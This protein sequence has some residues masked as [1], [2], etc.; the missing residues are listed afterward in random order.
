VS[1]A[2][3]PGVLAYSSKNLTDYMAGLI[4]AIGIER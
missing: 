4:E 2:P 3:E 1:E